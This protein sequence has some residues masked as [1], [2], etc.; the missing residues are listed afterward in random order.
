MKT[1]TVSEYLERSAD[2]LQ[3][4]EAGEEVEISR[5]GVVVARLVPEK[6]AVAE[7]ANG[8]HEGD[9]SKSAAFTR[10][11]TGEHITHEEVMS[12]LGRS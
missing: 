8:S 4:V 9:R 10:D 6:R 1:A 3:W 5:D 11:R 7:E 2:V 12:L